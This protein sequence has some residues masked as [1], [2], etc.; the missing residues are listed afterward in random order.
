MLGLF[1][2]LQ[3]W[4][5]LSPSSSGTS[6]YNPNF[7]PLP[8]ISVFPG[9]INTVSLIRFYVHWGQKWSYI[10]PYSKIFINAF[11]HKCS[12]SFTHIEKDFLQVGHTHTHTHTHTSLYSLFTLGIKN[13]PISNYISTVD[14]SITYKPRS[15]KGLRVSYFEY[16][17]YW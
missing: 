8:G 14:T 2:T 3:A 10:H 12:H 15:F 6:K 16:H 9:L 17:Y 1:L 7:T 5:D 4:S 13:G 11:A